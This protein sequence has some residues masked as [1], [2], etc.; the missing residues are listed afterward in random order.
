MQIDECNRVI[1]TGLQM[2]ETI[3]EIKSQMNKSDQLDYKNLVIR[4]GI[5]TGN[6][7]AELIGTKLVK[8]DIFGSNVLTASKMRMNAPSGTVCIS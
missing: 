1:A 5:H 4:V 7:I 6:I 8:Y 2:L 3:K